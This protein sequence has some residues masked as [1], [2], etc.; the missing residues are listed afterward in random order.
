[1]KKWFFLVFWVLFMCSLLI[2]QKGGWTWDIFKPA[3]TPVEPVDYHPYSSLKGYDDILKLQKAFIRNSKI[4]KP[5]VV[6]I[7]NLKE[8]PSKISFDQIFRGDPD[9]WFKKLRKWTIE[10]IRRKYQMESLGSGVIYDN[11]G[12]ILTNFHV[13]ENTDQ[14][15]VKTSDNREFSARIIGIDPLTDLA[16]LKIFSFADFAVPQFGES[17][18]LN[19]GTWVMAIGNPYGLEGTVTVGVV[20]GIERSDL[21]IATFE[22]FIQTDASINPGNSGGPLIN[23]DGKIIGINSAIAELGAGVGFAIPIE[24]A[25]KIA[26]ALIENGEVQRG[27]LGVGIQPLT[28]D[29]AESFKISKTKIGVLVNSL[30][31]GAP[32]EKAGILQGDVIINYDGKAVKSLKILQQYVAE[33][34]IGKSVPVKILRDGIEKIVIVKVGKNLS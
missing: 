18:K 19:V 2:T 20:S 8:I 23:L 31:E 27:W 9:H 14:I 5:S 11:R 6:S 28:P 3:A 30:D 34:K 25:L 21:G 17:Q 16:V 29:L 33:T 4:I 12:Y 13:I 26:E 32:A 24:M 7:N 22:N 15:L 1:M 10:K